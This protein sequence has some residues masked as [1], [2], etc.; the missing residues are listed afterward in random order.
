MKIDNYRLVV[1]DQCGAPGNLGDSASETARLINLEGLLGLKSIAKIDYLITEKGYVRHPEVPDNWKEQDFS[2]DQAQ[3]LFMV[4]NKDQKAQ[5]IDRLYK[6]K[7][8]LGNSDFVSPF[9]IA[10]IYDSQFLRTLF[11]LIQ[12][13]IFF[14]PFRWSDRWNRFEPS[15][16]SSADYLN[17]THIAFKSPKWFRRLVSKQKLK[18]KIAHYYSP[19]PDAF[20]VDLY[21]QAIDKMF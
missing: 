18:D 15:T 4:M 12:L 19:E 11:L 21:N 3:V 2:N 7:F 16:D 9:L 10:E 5:F 8:R 14:I 13:L 6:A 17:F 1:L 20:V